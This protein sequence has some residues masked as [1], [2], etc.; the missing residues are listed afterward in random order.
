MQDRTG[1]RAVREASALSC[2]AMPGAWEGGSMLTEE[3]SDCAGRAILCWLATVDA[4][5]QPNVSPKEI[6]AVFDA[7]HLVIAHIA[8]PTSVRNIRS[9]DRVCVSFIDV[10]VQKGWKVSGSACLLGRDDAEYAHWVTPLTPMAGPR[11]PIHGVIVVQAQA[12]EAIIAPSYR[13]YPQE[14]TEASQ[15]AAALRAYRVEPGVGFESG[16]TDQ[17]EGL[18]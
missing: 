5:G 8:S 9:H 2:A 1:Q 12:V 11:F 7:Q 10:F 15:V 13:L 14:T 16:S 4:I 18:A 17:R 6:F 3:I